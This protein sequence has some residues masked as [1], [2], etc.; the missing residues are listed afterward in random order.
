MTEERK[1]SSV[2]NYKVLKLVMMTF[3][4]FLVAIG[5]LYAYFIIT[6]VG[7]DG[8]NDVLFTFIGSVLALPAGIVI[9]IVGRKLKGPIIED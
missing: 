9:C 6:T 7:W 8:I 1:K 4:T 3:G 2:F 5:P